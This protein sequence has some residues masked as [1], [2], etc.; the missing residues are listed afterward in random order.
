MRHSF[1]WVRDRG[2]CS[3]V[4]WQDF[5]HCRVQII[6]ALQYLIEGQ[7]TKGAPRAGGDGEVRERESAVVN[8]GVVAVVSISYVPK[9]GAS[10]IVCILLAFS[11]SLT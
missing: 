9:Q 4:R 2:R 8:V 3:A 1:C 11:S 6:L 10:I 5:E 7:Q